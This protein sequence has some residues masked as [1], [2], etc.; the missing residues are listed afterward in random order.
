MPG[1]LRDAA[2]EE[3]RHLRLP[4]WGWDAIVLIVVIGSAIL[5]GPRPPFFHPAFPLVMW[6]PAVLAGAL[7]LLRRRW[8]IPVL[9]GSLIIYCTT[10]VL[11]VPSNGAGIAMIIAGFGVA[12]R[13]SRR[14]A[15]LS[16]GLAAAAVA[17]LS[18][19]VA[20]LGVIDPRVFQ[21]AAGVAIAT[22]LGDSTRSRREYVA[23]VT[24]RAERAEQT[25]EAEAHRRVAEERLHIAQDL[26]DT[27]AHQLSVIS[28]NAGVA[29][30]TLDRR[31]EKAREAL[32]TIRTAA[33]GALSDIGELL[34]YL[35][36]DQ[37]H[38]RAMP[39]QVGLQQL[40]ALVQRFRA[41]GLQVHTNVTGDLF[42][43]TGAV[44][45]V[46]Y[47][48]VQEA[49]TNAHKHGAGH[50]ATV[51]LEVGDR[52]LR[53]TVINPTSPAHVNHPDAPGDRLGL[54]GVQERVAAV[55][56]TVSAQN[57]G[58]HFRLAAELPLPEEV[59]A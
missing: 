35:R 58:D 30:G 41:A 54:V 13:R 56:G 5:P 16:G 7:L 48:I 12:N 20:E 21:M 39:P 57:I 17:V 3:V 6:L 11:G 49:L 4:S 22:A 24:E 59:P 45:L 25:R 15:F 23:A 51:A 19:T 31:P 46:A 14:L 2:P 47:R 33:R 32:G 27:V 53:I 34:H 10:V 44:D 1:E 42:Q 55:R 8:P 36:T 26:H 37:E 9:A 18:V 40:D 43:V 52:V 28:L 38:T 50:T 29:T